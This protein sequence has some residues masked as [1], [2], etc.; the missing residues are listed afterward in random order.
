MEQIRDRPMAG[1]T[2]LITGATSGIGRA[3]ALGLAAMGAHV[4]IIGRD[5]QPPTTRLDGSGQ[6]AGVRRMCS[7][8]TCPHNRRCDGWPR[9]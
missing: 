5:R 6:P 3:T 9:R 1:K 7:S 8:R 4:A 2:V